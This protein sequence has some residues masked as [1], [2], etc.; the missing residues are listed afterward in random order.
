MAATA[1]APQRVIGSDGGATG[2]GHHPA[3]AEPGHLVRGG[4]PIEQGLLAVL[5]GGGWRTLDRARRAAGARRG[6]RLH[7][8]FDLDEGTAR[9]VVRMARRLRR[10]EHGGETSVGALQQ[11]APLVARARLE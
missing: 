1:A 6:R 9:A 10:R 11:G 3:L 4:A 2:S 5:A 7:H 8:V